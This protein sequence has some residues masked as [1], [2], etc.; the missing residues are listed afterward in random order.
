MSLL[1]SIISDY[2]DKSIVLQ[3]ILK[4]EITKIEGKGKSKSPKTL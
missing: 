2:D 3:E 1:V 4:G